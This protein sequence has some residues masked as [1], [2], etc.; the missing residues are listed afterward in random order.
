[1]LIVDFKTNQAPPRL[2]AEAPA[3][4]VASLRSTRAI[5]R[6]LYPQRGVRR[7]TGLD[8]TPELMEISAPRWTRTGIPWRWLGRT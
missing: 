8:E 6:K 3:S 4:Y 5:L 1:V 7:R 2:A